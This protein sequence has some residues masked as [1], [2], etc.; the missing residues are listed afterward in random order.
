MMRKSVPDGWRGNVCSH[1][2]LNKN[3]VTMCVHYY[4]LCQAYGE[5][6]ETLFPLEVMCTIRMCYRMPILYSF[7]FSLVCKSLGKLH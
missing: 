3:V 2:M 4:L 6:N 7:S 5:E 1:S